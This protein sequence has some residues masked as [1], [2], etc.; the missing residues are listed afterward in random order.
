MYTNSRINAVPWLRF[1]IPASASDFVCAVALKAAGISK[2]RVVK[3]RSEVE[4]W[5]AERGWKIS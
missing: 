5:A 1:K 3:A 2:E 4:V